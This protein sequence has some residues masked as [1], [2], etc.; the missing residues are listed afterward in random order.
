MSKQTRLF[1]AQCAVATG[2][3]AFGDPAG[4]CISASPTAPGGGPDCVGS[5]TSRICS[6]VRSS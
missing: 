6:N 1:L 4:V 2:P 5:G 3:L